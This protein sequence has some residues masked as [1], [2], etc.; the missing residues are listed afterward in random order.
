MLST[1]IWAQR[2]VNDDCSNASEI[3]IP[4]NG[5]G[6]G[7]LTSLK[8][9][10][11]E[12]SRQQAEQ[13][14]K[15]LDDVGNCTKTV[16]YK[17][18]IPTT[19]N[20]SI[21]LT[22]QDSAIP[23]IFAGFN[24]YRIPDCSYSIAD[25]EKGLPPLNK[26][27]VSGNSCLTQGWYLVQVGC[28]KKAKG[29]LWV[30]L[31]ISNSNS[32]PYDNLRGL[33]DFGLVKDRRVS[34]YFDFSCISQE[35][36]E[37]QKVVDSSIAKSI[38]IAVSFPSKMLVNKIWYNYK[39]V[40]LEGAQL[41]YRLFAD[42][43]TA[44]SFINPKPYCDVSAAGII[45]NEQCPLNNAINKRYYLQ[46]LTDRF[47]NNIIIY[48][49]NSTYQADQWNTTNTDNE[50]TLRYGTDTSML[51]SL[52]C[53]ALM[54]TH[55]CK[56]VIPNYFV[57]NYIE[58]N[59]GTSGV[60]NVS[61]TFQFGSYSILNIAQNGLLHAR[62]ENYASAEMVHYALYAGDIRTSCN[63]VLVHEE[64]LQENNYYGMESCIAKGT[65]TLVTSFVS[66]GQ[67]GKK[68]RLVFGRGAAP[69]QYYSPTQPEYVK[70]FN[71]LKDAWFSSKKINFKNRDTNIFIDTVALSGRFTFKE[72]YI[73]ESSDFNIVGQYCDVLVFGGQISKGT[74]FALPGID[75]SKRTKGYGLYTASS[76]FGY[77]HLGQCFYLNKGYY[78]V[79][80]L[81]NKIDGKV[82]EDCFSTE[83][84]VNFIPNVTCPI[85]N[86]TNPQFAYPI[87]SNQDVLNS[88]AA[89]KNLT[90]TYKLIYCKDC[91]QTSTAKPA[92]SCNTRKFITPNTTY[93]YYTFFMAKNASFS[94]PSVFELYKG[95][96]Q[97]N[98]AIVIDS[99]NI[100]APCE[101]GNVI[102]N[103]EGNQFY[104][105]MVPLDI[106]ISNEGSANF[107]PL[108]Y[109][110]NDFAA[111]AY[112][113]GH[114]S[115]SDTRQ[116]DYVPI[117]CHTNGLLSDPSSDNYSYRQGSVLIPYPDTINIRRVQV[118]KNL[119]YTFTVSGST[120]IRIKSMVKNVYGGG[121]DFEVFQYKGNYEQD[122]NTLVKK[123]FDSTNTGMTFITNNFYRDSIEFIN[124]GCGIKRYFVLLKGNYRYPTN[125]EH[126]MV[127]S[128][129]LIASATNG[130]FCGDAVTGNY[131]RFGSY[132]LLTNNACHTYGNS[133]NETENSY[134][135]KSTWFKISVT[136]LD[137]FDLEI[138]PDGTSY[139]REYK[140]F[141][142]TCKAMTKIT[143]GGDG[144]SYFTLN[145]MGAGDY[146]IQ[147]IYYTYNN[148]GA[149]ATDAAFKVNIKN[150]INK[151]CK[152]YDFKY[153]IALFKIKGGCNRED[154]VRLINQSTLGESIT[155]H[156]YINQQFFSKANTPVFSRNKIG[157]KDTNQILLIVNN[158]DEY[159]SDTF[160]VQ[161][162]R[163]TVKYKFK[164]HGP[165]ISYCYDSLLLT[166]ETNYPNKINY[167]WR[168]YN[169][170]ED[171]LSTKTYYSAN[172]TQSAYYILTGE[173][174]NCQFTDTFLTRLVRTLHRYKDTSFCEGQ[175]YVIKNT[176]LSEYNM[177]IGYNTLYYGDS[178]IFKTSK[179]IQVNYQDRGCYYYDSVHIKVEMGP[180]NLVIKDSLYA[181]NIKT[182]KIEYIKEPL[183]KYNW[184]TGDTSHTLV[185]NKNGAY[186]LTGAFSKCRSLD[187]T[188]IINMDPLDVKRLR[189]TS[190]C[191]NEVYHF[192]NPFDASFRVLNQT[193]KGADIK[194]KNSF[195][196]I[197]NLQKSKCFVDDTADVT[198]YPFESRSIDSFYC[199]RQSLFIMRLDGGDAKT[200]NWYPSTET[201]RYFIA[202]DYGHYPVAR[203][204]N[205]GCQD[206]LDYRIITSCEFNVFVPNIFTPNDDYT[207]E[208]FGPSI[209]GL[210]SKYSMHIYN[211]WGELI[212]NTNNGGY[213][214]GTFNHQMVMNGVYT[215]FI[216][217]YDKNNEP[218]FFKGTV[219]V[220]Y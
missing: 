29:T 91:K 84:W 67:P 6:I 20:V 186:R 185:V 126:A 45:L 196:A 19:R 32:Q 7:K 34:N 48:V 28:K 219:T 11:T 42:T 157:L 73:S 123:G 195:K 9:D 14:V 135:I 212:Y 184:S 8:V 149:N 163:D 141:G 97:L 174:D 99:N 188:T 142:G 36:F 198:M 158:T 77:S 117:T 65:Y 169:T 215:Y 197:L 86:N 166:S 151:S 80:S 1:S 144:Y 191:K 139:L 85:P 147:A 44:D 17:F 102:C 41:K 47:Q 192:V 16:W 3:I 120:K 182:Y 95:N 216:T 21:T 78:T 18:Y 69:P 2:P 175:Q 152:P 55:A 107:T 167:A 90:Y 143:G 121:G 161:Y 4:S 109:S 63:L 54:S 27:G 189:D 10:I 71:P 138:Q 207:N 89:L 178:V 111:H 118:T 206:T 116:S 214:N 140:V 153:P 131:S 49:D 179:S 22:Q 76:W 125:L 129:K 23:Q 62:I 59:R 193:P 35:P 177:Y 30:E 119:W 209:S 145:C 58:S 156:W 162:I 130:D 92:L 220:L 190:L 201:K 64:F 56:N 146:F 75:Y 136:G 53:N 40:T 79:V 137:K 103:L 204:D 172:K 94:G 88:P 114:Y 24:T 33:F 187:L 176:Y 194:I 160:D 165:A 61:D 15:D 31:N 164:I 57:R 66:L 112:D 38:W 98:P 210:Y 180:R 50:I 87:N 115:T 173:S 122:F 133:P 108:Y 5:F 202:S 104:T 43:V 110:K 72:I 205:N 68:L 74:A 37:K 218:Y 124:V 171:P 181:C 105:L 25:I 217:V 170:Y 159:T 46:I 81:L 134:N 211:R 101:P 132:K 51:R 155:Y 100:I 52:N 93:Y 39:D 203:I 127:V 154:T 168:N 113:F 200:Y 183:L 26:F 13:C 83:H 82:Y 96:A 70:D 60:R 199:N 208:V 213:W 106:K 12:A 128:T 150:P 148:A